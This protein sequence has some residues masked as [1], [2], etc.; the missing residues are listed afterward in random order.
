GLGGGGICIV[1]DRGRGTV[2]EFDFLAR[3]ASGGGAYAVPG[4][5]RGFALMQSLYGALPWQRDVSPGE[6]YAAAGFPISHALAP[7]LAAA[8][9]I[10]RLDASLAGEFLDEGG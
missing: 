8:R 3:D 2:E 5:V 4:N 10:I 9:D 7:R 6:E 1:Q